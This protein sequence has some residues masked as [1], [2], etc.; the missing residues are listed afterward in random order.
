LTGLGGNRGGMP[1]SF[2]PGFGTLV[3]D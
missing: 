3:L 1:I 2:G